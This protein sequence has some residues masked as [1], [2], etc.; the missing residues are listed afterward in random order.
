MCLGLKVE[1]RHVAVGSQH[2]IVGGARPVRHAL[3]RQIW[4]RQHEV[5]PV[6]LDLVEGFLLGLDLDSL[7]AVRRHQS[8]G[9]LTGTLQK[10][11]LLARLVALALQRL[12]RR[13]G[14]AALRVERREPPQLIV[15]SRPTSS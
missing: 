6:L 3:V 13:N 5:A 9:I 4:Q 15:E 2:R 7:L 8:V 11:D 10:G 14:R 1:G 12:E